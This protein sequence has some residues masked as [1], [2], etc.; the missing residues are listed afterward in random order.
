[1]KKIFLIILGLTM[2]PMAYSMIKWVAKDGMERIDWQWVF[3]T[4]AGEFLM[5]DLSSRRE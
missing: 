1:M 4:L 2:I 3:R 5:E